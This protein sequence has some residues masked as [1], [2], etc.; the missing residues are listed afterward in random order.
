[1]C[2]FPGFDHREENK[3][4]EYVRMKVYIHMALLNG[5]LTS[6]DVA[7]A[8]GKGSADRTA[9]AGVEVKAGNMP[10]QLEEKFPFRKHAVYACRVAATKIPSVDWKP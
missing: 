1:M 5:G 6:L 4:S 8:K 10:P 7:Y 3:E 9:F 2:A